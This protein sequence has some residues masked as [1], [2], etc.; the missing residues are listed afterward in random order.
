MGT[1]IAVMKDGMLQQI[2]T[3]QTLYDRP[4][5]LFVAGFMGS[6][7]MNFFD[8]AVKG[9]S[10]NILIEGD[11]FQLPIPAART[12]GMKPYLG[13][14]VTMGIRPENLHDAN[15]VP[16]NIHAGKL[17]AKV[18]VTEL[19]GNEIFLYLITGKHS[20]LARVDPRTQA[21]VGST[22]QISANLD[23]VHF[24]DKATEKAI[25]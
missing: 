25:R 13:K 24:F 20:Y 11:G 21:R 17:E 10:D 2:D 14:E 5:N 23:S 7:S 3:P 6:P 4:V 12:A 22:L 1:R 15:F 18:D 19:M 9:N 16:P 8:V